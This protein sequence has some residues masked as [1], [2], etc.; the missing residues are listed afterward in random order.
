[1]LV[2]AVS[3]EQSLKMEDETAFGARKP[4]DP[5]ERRPLPTALLNMPVVVA[6]NGELAAARRTVLR[7][8]HVPL[9]APFHLLVPMN[10]LLAREFSV[11]QGAAVGFLMSIAHVSPADEGRIEHLVALVTRE[12][13]GLAVSVHLLLDLGTERLVLHHGLVLYLLLDYFGT[14]RQALALFVVIFPLLLH[15][16]DAAGETVEFQLVL[17]VHF[18]LS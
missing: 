16:S 11:A 10:L 6:H 3:L 4:T 18:G 7:D 13:L 1:M 2:G 5:G 14:A 15:D 8:R 17:I 9:A 12:A